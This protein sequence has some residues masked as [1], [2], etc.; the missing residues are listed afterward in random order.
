MEKGNL[1]FLCF[2]C[3]YSMSPQLSES[4]V[5]SYSLLGVAEIVQPAEGFGILYLV[6][7]TVEKTVL[8]KERYNILSVFFCSLKLPKATTCVRV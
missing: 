8:L 2:G 4:N 1:P 3:I 5:S 6:A 7:P